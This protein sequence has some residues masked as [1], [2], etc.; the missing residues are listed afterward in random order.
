MAPTSA[1][2]ALASSGDGTVLGGDGKPVIGTITP[3]NLASFVRRLA[4]SVENWPEVLVRLSLAS[5]GVRAPGD[6]RTRVRGGPVV[7]SPPARPAWW[8]TFEM[9]AEDVY[10]LG[11]LGNLELRRGEVV[12]DIGA[13][14]GTAALLFARRWPECSLVCVEPNPGTFAYLRT[15]LDANQVRATARNEAVGAADGQTV[16][17]GVDDASCEASTSVEVPGSSA[18]VPV[19]A[20]ER[21]LA[22][23]PG[24]VRVVKLD[25]EG[26]EHEILAASTPELWREVEV[27][28]LEY[29]RT[30]DPA[31][32]WP[33]VEA[34]VNG[35]GLATL[36]HMPFAW[37]PGLGM[38]A[39][40]RPR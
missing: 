35:L 28:L 6:I 38:A 5:A 17:F 18:K 19:V 33:A 12:V 11:A 14:I 4:G 29:H 34:R 20:F 31:S 40:R 15:N 23:A 30:S 16:L 37:A 2:T 25:C 3:A 26:A 1:S 27:L 8:P 36:W 7:V 21:L 24:P 22:E 10:R 39:F 32:G 9:F 13:H